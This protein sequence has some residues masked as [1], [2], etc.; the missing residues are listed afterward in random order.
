MAVPL[1]L[2]LMMAVVVVHW[3]TQ[4]LAGSASR[5]IQKSMRQALAKMPVCLPLRDRL[6][7]W[8]RQDR[9][10]ELWCALNASLVQL[11]AAV[12]QQL[13]KCLWGHLLWQRLLSQR[14]HCQLTPL[15]LQ[16]QWAAMPRERCMTATAAAC[17]P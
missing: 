14:G 7:Q 13:L 11:K 2:L 17:A 12:Y 16:P 15:P 6:T 5:R 1:L 4:A 8:H 10:C 9:R 3:L